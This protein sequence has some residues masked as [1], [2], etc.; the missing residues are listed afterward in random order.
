MS[1]ISTLGPVAQRARALF[2]SLDTDIYEDKREEKKI[3]ISFVSIGY[4]HYNLMDIEIDGIS[5]PLP[6]FFADRNRYECIQCF[7][8]VEDVEE[9][10]NRICLLSEKS[11]EVQHLRDILTNIEGLSET[12]D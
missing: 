7:H 12:D 1:D 5:E 8:T 9:Y 3:D 4:H 10:R 11:S 2:P 6:K